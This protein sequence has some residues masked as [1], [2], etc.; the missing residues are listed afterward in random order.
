MRSSLIVR[1]DGHVI[2]RA[3]N[4]YH[5]DVLVPLALEFVTFTHVPHLQLLL[6][7]TIDFN[8]ATATFYPASKVMVIL[9]PI[10]STFAPDE[11]VPSATTTDKAQHIIPITTNSGPDELSSLIADAHELDLNSI[12]P[13]QAENKKPSEET[14]SEPLPFL[15]FTKEAYLKM[16]ADDSNKEEASYG[17]LYEDLRE[18]Q[19]LKRQN[20]SIVAAPTI[21]E[22]AVASKA[23]KQDF[24]K[25]L[26]KVGRNESCPCGSG[27]KFKTCHGKDS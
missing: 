25:M 27:K 22:A 24:E 7:F 16:L 5:L 21:Q 26:K 2:M 20:P 18:F 1:E 6:P 12:G 9:V 10:T 17:K 4:R 23:R 19:L 3:E 15:Q 13:P 8:G 11:E 14:K